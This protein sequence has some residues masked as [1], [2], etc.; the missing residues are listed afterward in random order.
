MNNKLSYI[1]EGF[2][3]IHIKEEVSKVNMKNDYTQYIPIAS[4][5]E[6]V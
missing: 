4:F 1:G 5:P 3:S 2:P 6:K